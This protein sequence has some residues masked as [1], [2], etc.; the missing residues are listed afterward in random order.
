MALDPPKARRRAPERQAD[1]AP[2]HPPVPPALDVAR[3]VADGADHVLDAIGRREEA[4]QARRQPQRQNREGFLEPFAQTGRGVHVAIALEPRRQGVEL[5]PRRPALRKMQ[6]RVVTR[7][8]LVA[9]SVGS[10]P[11]RHLVIYPQ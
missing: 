9:E 7:Y 11:A 6:H 8:Q 2:N 3:D 4:L 1:P 10:E 5:T